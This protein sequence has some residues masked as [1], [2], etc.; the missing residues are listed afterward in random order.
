MTPASEFSPT[1]ITLSASTV[2]ETAVAGDVVGDIIVA[3][4]DVGETFT[5]VLDNPS[6]NFE[7]VDGKLVVKA[8]ANL[9]IDAGREDELHPQ[10]HRDGFRQQLRHERDADHHRQSGQRGSDRHH[11]VGEHGRR[12]RRGGDVVG[13]II[14]ADEDVGDSFTYEIDDPNFEIVDGKLVVKAGA[15]LDLDEGQSNTLSVEVTVTDSGGL[16]HQETLV[17]TIDP[18]DEAPSIIRPAAASRRPRPPRRP[19]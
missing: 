14:V 9:D 3:D 19:N 18:I 8:G 1:D 12:D 11:P 16:S 13:D 4:E 15:D 17:V 5:Y 10:H 7:I 6:G 2:D